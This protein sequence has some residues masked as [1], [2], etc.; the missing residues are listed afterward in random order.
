MKKNNMLRIASVLL[1]AVLLSTCAI[2]GA[3]AKYTT[4]DKTLGDTARVAKFGVTISTTGDADGLFSKTEGTTPSITVNSTTED[5]MVA[6]GMGGDLTSAIV[7]TEAGREVAVKVKVAAT[8][9]LSDDWKADG[10]FYCPIVI[11]VGSESVSGLDYT[12]DSE[13]I[14]DVEELIEANNDKTYYCEDQITDAN[15]PVISWAWV[16][17]G[18]DAKDTV[19]GEAGVGTIGLSITTSIEQV[20]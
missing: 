18:Q 3:F 1:V 6:P 13:F 14:A 8:M 16:F 4:G 17:D 5:K 19:L 10:A 7:F 15:I 11:T 12:T 9:T 20:D 2:S